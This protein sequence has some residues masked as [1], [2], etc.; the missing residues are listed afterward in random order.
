VARRDELIEDYL[1]A[2]AIELQSLGEPREV[3]TLFFGGGTPTHLNQ[4]QFEQLVALARDWFS[5]APEYEFSVESNPHYPAI[6]Y[7]PELGVTRLS[8]GG[9]S[10]D[11]QK[12]TTLERDHTPD[13]LQQC[14]EY[15]RAF[16]SGGLDLIF[17]VPGETLHTWRND[18]TTAIASGIPHISTYGLTFE[19]GTTFWNRRQKGR[20]QSL[21]EETEREM[22]ALAIDLLTAAGYEHYEVS[23]FAKPGHRCR[24]NEAYWAGESYFAAGPGAARYVNGRREMNH[25]SVTTW[26][27]RVLAGQSPVAEAEELGPEDRARELLVFGLRRMEGVERAEFLSRTGFVLDTI[28]GEPL[29]RFLDLGLFTDDGHNVRLTRAGLFVSDSIWPHF[30]G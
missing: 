29:R 21:D 3:D 12:L 25:R 7:L 26:L 27:K 28:A 15:S 9:Q 18:L 13:Q 11:Q 22:Y 5:L 17:G 2:L 19:Q 1:K 24:H 10:L 23:N 16:R 14:L 6:V 8:L 20:M 30:L 4:Q